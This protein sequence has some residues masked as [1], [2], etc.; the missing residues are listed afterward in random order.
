MKN[1]LITKTVNHIKAN[2]NLFE[3][4]KI[5]MTQKVH[6]N[7]EITETKTYTYLADK[8]KFYYTHGGIVG[9]MDA[10]E[11]MES[12]FNTIELLGSYDSIKVENH[13]KVIADMKRI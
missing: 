7:Y 12:I 3:G 2:I 10:D 5:T 6:A 9:M 4:V 8:D 13:G 11:A 1:A